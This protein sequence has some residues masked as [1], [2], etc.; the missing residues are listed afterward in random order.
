LTS[1]SPTYTYPIY[2][3]LHN[4]RA[5]RLQLTWIDDKNLRLRSMCGFT[6]EVYGHS[7]TVTVYYVYYA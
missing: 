5:K 2:N 4:I 7:T 6:V 1:E 3:Y